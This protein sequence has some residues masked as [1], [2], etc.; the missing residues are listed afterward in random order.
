MNKDDSL[1]I[2]GDILASKVVSLDLVQL[3]LVE[4]DG[5]NRCDTITGSERRLVLLQNVEVRKGSPS[6]GPA[7]AVIN[8]DY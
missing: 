4:V 5:E 2:E 3:L 6:E 8:G 7:D 1:N